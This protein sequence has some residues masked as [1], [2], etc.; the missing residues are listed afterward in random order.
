MDSASHSAQQSTSHVP[1]DSDPHPSYLANALGVL[2]ALTTLAFPIF[3]IAHF[4]AVEADVP[5][6]S[7]SP[8][9]RMGNER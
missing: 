8:M 2:I 9:V 6:R 7:L 1:A 5:Q 4:S 3:S